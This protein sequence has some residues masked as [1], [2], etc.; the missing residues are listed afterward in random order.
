MMGNRM[1]ISRNT[2]RAWEETMREWGIKKSHL[3]E[4]GYE[5]GNWGD[6]TMAL[7]VTCPNGTILRLSVTEVM[8]IPD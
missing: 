4:L 6:G 8:E 5:F 2:K 1:A 3:K 7:R